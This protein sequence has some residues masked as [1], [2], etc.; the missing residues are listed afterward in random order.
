MTTK[1]HR[2][3]IPL[4]VKLHA[5]MLLLKWPE[6]RIRGNLR[7]GRHPQS[8]AVRLEVCLLELGF[9]KSDIAAGIDFD[10][11]PALAFREIVNGVMTPAS[12]DP[13][14]LRPM[15]RLEHKKKTSGVPHLTAG[16]DVHMA[17]KIRRITGETPK[18]KSRKLQ[19]RGFPKA[20]KKTPPKGR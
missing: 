12:N 18:P 9:S 20:Q 19:S 15:K 2:R 7:P 3:A 6:W 14:F 5:C 4:G 17:G 8:M 10:H 13:K 1:E 16:S 11:Q